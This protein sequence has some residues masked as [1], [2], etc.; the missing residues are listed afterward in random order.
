MCNRKARKEKPGL[1]VIIKTL[2][3]APL[4]PRDWEAD[5]FLAE[6]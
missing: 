4:P 5:C 1:S 2:Q 3:F 6:L